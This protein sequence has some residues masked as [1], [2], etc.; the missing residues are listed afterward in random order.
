M[1]TSENKNR[2]LDI[3]WKNVIKNLFQCKASSV[4]NDCNAANT[5]NG[6]VDEN[7]ASYNNACASNNENIDEEIVAN[8]CNTLNHRN[9]LVDENRISSSEENIVEDLTPIE[10]FVLPCDGSS[11]N[12]IFIV[13]IVR[14]QMVINAEPTS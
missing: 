14:N 13:S 10:E 5:R 8:N 4:P 2:I 1:N 7:R 9:G 3:G 6:P 11:M 12:D